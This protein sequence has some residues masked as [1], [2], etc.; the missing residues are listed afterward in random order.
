MNK[1]SSINFSLERLLFI[2]AIVSYKLLY[3]WNAW[4]VACLTIK[5]YQPVLPDSGGE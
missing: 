1:T 3:R 4:V 2:S 5:H